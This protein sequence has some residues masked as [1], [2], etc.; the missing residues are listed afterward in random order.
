[1]CALKTLRPE[2]LGASPRMRD[3]FVREA[4]IWCGLW[5]HANLLT[6]ELMDAFLCDTRFSDKPEYAS[7]Q[8][9]LVLDY[10][11][12]RSLSDLLALPPDFPPRLFWAQGIPAGLLALHTPIPICSGPSRWRT[13]TSSPRTC[14]LWRMDERCSPPVR[15]RRSSR[16]M[17]LPSPS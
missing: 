3:R 11:E 15:W 4:L 13:A 17:P 16:A 8:P 1:W 14:S 7:G 12:G 6:T 2:L 5:P 9:F 10:A